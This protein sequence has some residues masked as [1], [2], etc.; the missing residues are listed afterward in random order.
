MQLPSGLCLAILLA[1]PV[2]GMADE[3]PKLTTLSDP[4]LR[5]RI[6]E[7]P[8]QI[9]KRAGLTAVIVDNQAV[10]DAVLPGHRAGYSGV[11]SLTSEMLPSNFFVPAVSGLNFEHIHDG[12]TQ[13]RKILFEPRHHPME[14]RVLDEF[15]VE[16]YQTPTPTWGLESCHRYHL[17]PDGA[18]E[19]TFECI[20]R[21]ATFKNGYIGLFWASYIHQPES[22][23]IHFRGFDEGQDKSTTRWIRGV[24][25]AHGTLPTHLAQDDNRVFAHDVD[26]P[27]SLVF[28]RSKHRFI[29]PWYFG[30][31]HGQA[32]AQMFRPQD[33]VRL[34]QSPSG[35]GQGN[36]AW[37]FQFFI[38][39]YEL[40]RRYQ[41]VMRAMLVPFESA[42]QVERAT[43]AHRAALSA[44]KP[45]ER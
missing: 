6:P 25:P 16:L 5:Y 32:Y 13:D 3:P 34:T 44:P 31:S 11:A 12:T 18:I 29:E 17:L 23:D 33:R 36:P 35:G 2:V 27:L 39:K 7:K 28:N 19:L 22:L 45:S 20:P 26:F 43:R 4:S 38:D 14:L 37:D 1:V 30:V 24:T 21:R 40:N 42:E 10:D 9:L 15:T 41:F 8:Y